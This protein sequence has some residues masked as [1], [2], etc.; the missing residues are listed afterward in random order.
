MSP[1]SQLERAQA[2]WDR[3]AETWVD[4]GPPA[5]PSANDIE[6]YRVL[7]EQ[8]TAPRS[9]GNL[10]ILGST[11]SLRN[12][13]ASAFPAFSVTCVD[14]SVKMY[15]RMSS[16][17]A[18]ANSR[19]RFHQG[20]WCTF[21]LARGECDAILGDK[22]IDN[23]MP[24]KWDDL[25][26]N[27]HRQLRPGGA[28][29]VHLALVDDRFRDTNL[30]QALSKW[31]RRLEQGHDSLR[32]AAAGLW[33][34]LLTASA[35]KEGYHNTVT[36]SRFADEMER[37]AAHEDDLDSDARRLLDEF[38]RVFWS[39]RD[40]V[41]SSYDYADIIARMSPYFFHEQTLYS[42]DYDVASV[43][44]LVLMRARGRQLK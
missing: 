10:L 26:A 43:Q 13:V 9:A 19:E 39:S 29:I 41:W 21:A 36:T 30:D 31:S 34:D 17:I 37:L 28:F 20:D 23:V 15:D 18:V 42:S 11:P 8:A 1:L 14:F 2:K 44:P 24:D 7:L 4:T 32:N 3:L 5:S 33:E 6:H 25:F 27:I 38:V 35:Y 12:L 40:D 22:C 16:A